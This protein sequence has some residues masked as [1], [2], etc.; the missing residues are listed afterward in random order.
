MAVVLSG[1]G[2]RSKDIGL[3]ANGK[4]VE[5]RENLKK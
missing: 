3:G 2:Q 4:F 5:N 1:R